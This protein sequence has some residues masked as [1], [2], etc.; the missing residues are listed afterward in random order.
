LKLLCIAG[1]KSIWN[2]PRIKA[3][4]ILE[5]SLCYQLNKRS[6]ASFGITIFKATVLA[7][8]LGFR[9]NKHSSASFDRGNF[10]GIQK[11]I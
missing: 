6:P 3:T 10:Q 5:A 1:S 2:P 9:F 7:G 8:S 11:G 4:P